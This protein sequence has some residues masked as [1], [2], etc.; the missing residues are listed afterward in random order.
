MTLR[1]LSVETT[2]RSPR[3]RRLV[4]SDGSERITSQSVVR[5]LRLTEGLEIGDAGSFSADLDACERSCARQRSFRA[6]AQR[7]HSR[8]EL[9]ARLADDGY[10][11]EVAADTLESL[12]RSG[13]VDDERFAEVWARSRA[14]QGFGR[15]RIGE[16]LARR[17]IDEELVH[18][19][20]DAIAGDE[21]TRARSTLRGPVPTDRKARERVLRRLV[22]RGFDLPFAL[23]ALDAEPE[24]ETP[25]Q[26][27]S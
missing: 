16:E 15:R 4:F 13:L 24:D 5:K 18:T 22:G 11:A 7:E 12:V 25:A 2:G 19:A 23:R 17:G 26:D 3:A 27:V 8:A 10:P 1:L 14:H 20:L 9:A 6:L 21:V